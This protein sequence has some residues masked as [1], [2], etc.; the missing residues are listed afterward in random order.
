MST[1]G[2]PG[3]LPS[4]RPV[5]PQRGSF[6]LDHDG[7]CKDV[8]M[9]YLS[10]IK[11]V[12][13]MNEDECRMLAKSY[14]AC[15]MDR[16][17]MARDEF[18]NLGFKEKTPA[19]QGNGGDTGVKGE[20]RCPHPGRYRSLWTTSALQ[21]YSD[22]LPNLR[23]GSHT[24]VIFQGFT[25]KQATANAKDSI[26][27]GTNIVGGVTPGRTAE[28]LGL[29]VLP[30]VRSAVEQLKPDA[31]AIYVAAHQAAAAIEE[32]IEAEVPLIVAVAE[33]IPLHDML[34]I[35]SVLQSQSKSRLVG[36]N[37]P[38]I[39]SAVG[40]CRIGFQPLPCFT[41]GRVGIVAKSGT[42]SYEAVASITRA[43]IG[44][45]LC[46]GVGGDIVPGT[47]LR[48]AL[49]VLEQDPDTDAIALIGE[50]GGTGEL[51]AADW[52]DVPDQDPTGS[53]STVPG[54][55]RQSK[56]VVAL[57]AGVTETP[58]R[59]MGHAGAFTITGEPSAEAKIA[60]LEAAGATI[61]DHPAKFGGALKARLEARATTT[62]STSTG[63]F[64]G[65]GLGRVQ[66]R[67]FHTAARRPGHK[68][69]SPPI[70]TGHQ[71]R[72]LYISEDKSMDL[73]REVGRINCGTYSGSGVRKFLAIGIDRSTRSPCILASP[74]MGQDQSNNNSVKSYPFD[75]RR[76]L[77]EL[78]IGR[79]ASHMQM[80]ARGSVLESLGRLVES[81]VAIFYDK[82]AFFLSTSVVERLGEIKVVGARFGFDDAAYRSCGRQVDLQ[83]LRDIAA[84]DPAEVEAE[85]N[86]IVY[87]KLGGAGTVGTV[88]NGAGLAM[89]TV[90]ALSGHATNFLD[91]GGKATSETVKQSFSVVLQ[92]PRVRVIFV[93]IFG[94]LTLGDMI[95]RGIIMAFKELSVSV[96][97]VVRIRGTNEM[98]GQKLI[99]ES[100][101]P[102]YSFDD[103]EEAAA[104]AIELSK[105]LKL[106]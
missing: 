105:K 50:I 96:P 72:H 53:R 4:T 29:P 94:G 6:P 93:N 23:I 25:G 20:L 44:Q 26:A 91:T 67:Q 102:L 34:R 15:R 21:S 88:V 104:K 95:A 9:S 3:P 49:S 31:T 83:N 81:L 78:L 19:K 24:R 36:P 43:G 77:D 40:R 90:D 35:H 57:I 70:M 98:E 101:F 99:A 47:D 37:S 92:D 68:K 65:Q 86:G 64:G 13:G 74:A 61:I 80:S 60:A 7:E 45:S 38:G 48:E 103:F 42:L 106:A 16:N 18:K 62:E 87:I 69:Q 75:Y 76:G 63:G 66:R 5:P 97:V 58:G 8:M 11:K 52:K 1:F 85:K 79:I 71:R 22:T 17:L 56:P 10:C 51:A 59:I 89:N 2:S 27:W 54:R 55:S 100:G 73:L 82:E 46:I 84:E 30:T 28:H 12:K 32:A 41:P 33:H 39:I 14:L